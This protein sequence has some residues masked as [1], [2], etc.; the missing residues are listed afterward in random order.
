M[1]TSQRFLRPLMFIALLSPLPA[2]AYIDPNTGGMIFQV[3][4]PILAMIT[5][6]WLFARDRIKAA[7]YKVRRMIFPARNSQTAA[8][9][10]SD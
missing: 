4:A 3:L 9:P 10:D 8:N 5:S 6:A 2:M 1:A 7:F